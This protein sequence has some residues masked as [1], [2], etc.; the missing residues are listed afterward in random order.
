MDS[1]LHNVGNVIG[2]KYAS[3]GE[4]P[5]QIPAELKS[6]PGIELT[7]RGGGVFYENLT[8]RQ[9]AALFFD[10]CMDLI[11]SGVGQKPDDNNHYV[12]EC[13][14]YNTNQIQVN[15]WNGRDI[16]VPVTKAKLGTYVPSYTGGTKAQWLIKG[17]EVMDEWE[18]KFTATGG[19]FPVT[20]FWDSWATSSNGGISEGGC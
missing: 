9:N 11:A 6:S 15:G 5:T 4:Y 3:S 14:I 20:G 12:S 7:L 2:I 1:D 10:T 8:P 19:A 13:R 17:Q 18:S 16:G